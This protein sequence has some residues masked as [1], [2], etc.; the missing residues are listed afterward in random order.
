MF[1]LYETGVIVVGA[2][3]IF[4]VSYWLS[5]VL[6]GLIAMPIFKFFDSSNNDASEKAEQAAILMHQLLQIKSY[7]NDSK[8]WESVQYK[9]FGINNNLP[10]YTRFINSYPEMRSEKLLKLSK[11]KYSAY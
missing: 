4:A 1:Y 5:L 2:I 3:L 8:T 10:L 9:A 11:I 6:I 7:P